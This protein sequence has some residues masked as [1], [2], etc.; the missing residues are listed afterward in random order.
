M[1]HLI[2]LGLLAILSIIAVELDN[3][4]YSIISL[5]GAGVILGIIFFTLGAVYVSVF[6]I[7][8]YGGAITILFFTLVNMTEERGR[9]KPL[10][11]IKIIGVEVPGMVLLIVLLCL[12]L[13]LMTFY[14]FFE[15]TYTPTS[16]VAEQISVWVWNYRLTDTIIQA[17]VL[18]SALVGILV[19]WW[20]K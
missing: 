9:P 15:G 19:V 5:A 4:T 20:S 14:S 10:P 2:L 18:F 1:I 3:F 17:F 6:Q 11:P 8:I 7:L 13:G 12:F 16:E